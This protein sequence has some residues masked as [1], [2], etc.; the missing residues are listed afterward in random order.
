MSKSLSLTEVLS[1]PLTGWDS[2][3]Y[4]VFAYASLINQIL[5]GVEESVF[6]VSDH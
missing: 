3:H 2:V 4:L 1:L 5:A 6:N